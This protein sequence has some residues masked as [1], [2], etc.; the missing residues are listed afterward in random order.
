MHAN[1]QGINVSNQ[2]IYVRTKVMHHEPSSKYPMLI[3]DNTICS[4]LLEKTVHQEAQLQ[5][6]TRNLNQ[7]VQTMDKKWEIRDS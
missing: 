7:D 1:N 5:L 2:D 3:S 4:Y 6:Q